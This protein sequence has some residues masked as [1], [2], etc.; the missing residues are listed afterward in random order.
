MIEWAT[1]LIASG[2]LA[3]V[4]LLMVAENLFPPLP[5]EVIMSLAGFAAAQGKMSFFGVVLAGVAGA[6]AGNAVWFELARAFGAARTRRL[7]HRYGSYVWIGPEEV[8]K[9]EET[10]RRHGPVAVFI[11]RFMP[12]VRTAISVPAGLVELPRHV[13][14]GWTLLGTAIWT[15]GLAL[16]GYLLQEQY[17]KV[18]RWTGPIGLGVTVLVMAVIA[19]HVW[20]ARRRAG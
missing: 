15:T 13:F 19:W 3:G 1:S 2:G 10:M 9:A 17:E 4:F 11:G 6:V 20:K 8:A 5:S 16:A 7:L 12:G 14:Y 18:E